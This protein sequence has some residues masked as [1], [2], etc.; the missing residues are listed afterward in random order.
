MA[1]SNRQLAIIRDVGVGIEDHTGKPA[2]FFTT[3]ITESHA[4]GQVFHL[5][6]PDVPGLKYDVSALEGQPCWVIVD[7]P[8][9][10][11]DGW[12]DRPSRQE[13]QA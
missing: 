10:R 11:F 4:A 6:T 3:Y 12:W 1:E 2:I 13:G 7:G 8:F 5:P 9:I